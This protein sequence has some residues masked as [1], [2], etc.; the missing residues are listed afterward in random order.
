MDTGYYKKS[1]YIHLWIHLLLKANHKGTKVIFCGK[2][3]VI[4]PGQFLTGRKK[5]S[6]ETG[7]KQGTVE[8]ILK[9]LE[10][11]Q[12]IEQQKYNLFRLIT[13]LNY[14][15]Y[16]NID[17]NIDNKLTTNCQQNDTNNKDNND[18]KEEKERDT[19]VSPKKSLP[20]L[21]SEVEKKFTADE[22]LLKNDFLDYW[23]EKNP[24]GTKERWEMEK[25]FYIPSRFRRWI[26]NNL[27]RKFKNGTGVS[28]NKYGVHI[29]KVP[30]FKQLETKN[31]DSE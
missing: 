27:N 26:N 23:T 14:Y 3:M 17:N 6:E 7:I 22:L 13:I 31:D 16:Q 2:E 19:I 15:Q 10:I 12:Q 30:V 1:E 8:N 18:K 29:N 25:V 28:R 5:L 21:F 24:D 11:E 9:L 20:E 4:N